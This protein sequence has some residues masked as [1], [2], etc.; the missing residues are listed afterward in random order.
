MECIFH[1]FVLF[2]FKFIPS[3]TFCKM[4]KRSVEMAEE[5]IDEIEKVVE[6]DHNDDDESFQSKSNFSKIVFRAVTSSS[7]IVEWIYLNQILSAQQETR[8][9]EQIVIE[10]D[11]SFVF[12]VLKLDNRGE[13]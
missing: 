10:D 7:V 8:D 2:A 3:K 6:K 5:V 11:K 13:W 9:N 4:S 1:G 12:K